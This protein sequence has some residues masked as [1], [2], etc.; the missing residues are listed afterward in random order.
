MGEDDGP[1]FIGEAERITDPATIKMVG[2]QY[3]G[4]YFVAWLGFFRPRAER[5]SSGKTA[6]YRVRLRPAESES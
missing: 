5:V 1:Y 4:K 2:D 6:A 3:A